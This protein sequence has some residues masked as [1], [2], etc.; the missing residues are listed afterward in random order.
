M[1]QLIDNY[2]LFYYL[3]IKKN[4][5]GDEHFWSNTYTSAPHNTWKGLAFERVCLQ[6]IRQIKSA[7]GISGIQTN[8]CSW[9]V[10]GTSEQCGAQIDLV[11]QR[12]DGFTN[13]CE[14]K[15]SASTF[16]IDKDYAEALQ[17]KLDAYK[18]R[19]KDKRTLRLVMVTTNGIAH[20]N[21][22]NLVQN[23]VTMDDLFGV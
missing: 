4:A 16:V 1:Y 18:T 7:L 19:S 14:M 17:H 9:S 23:E 13:L 21:Y 2:T 11:I 10:R 22:Y 20:N 5:F 3:C 8:A 12:A 15:H 6:H